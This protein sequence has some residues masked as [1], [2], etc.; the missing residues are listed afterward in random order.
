M[1]DN[2]A[3]DRIVRIGAISASFVDS[4][5]AMP[6]LLNSGLALDYLVF[7]CLAEGVMSI[8]ARARLAGQPAYVSD[9]VTGQM[10]PF[11]GEIARRGIKVV[12]NAGGLDPQG[13]ADA[14]SV[15][16][17]EAGV[18]L[19][20]ACI[21]GDDL[22]DRMDK[23]VPA[24]T[25]DMFDGSDLRARLGDADQPLSL[26]AYT[27]AFPIAAA[28]EAGADIVVT[29]RAVDSATALGPLIHE[30]GWTDD[31][32]DLLSAGTLVGHLIECTTQVCGATF[33]DWREVP[34]WANIGFP[35]AECRG[36][37]SAVITKPEG[38]GG[39]V[40]RATVSE[41]MLYEIGDPASY[42]VPDVICD[43]TGVKAEEIGENR[44][45]ICGARGRGRPEKLKA[46]LTWDAGW[47]G[48]ALAPIMGFEAAAKAE[49]TAREL[50]IRCERLARDMGIAP[51]TRFHADVIGETGGGASMAICRMIADH[52]SAQGAGLFARE[53]SSIMT[54]MAVGTSVP[55]GTSVKPLTYFASL[56]LDRG[57]VDL[58]VRVDGERIEFV[59]AREGTAEIPANPSQPPCPMATAD[60]A[61]ALVDLAWVRSGD[62]GDLF[63]VGV[64]ARKSEYLPYLFDALTPAA[65]A[66]HYAKVLRQDIPASAVTRFH[67][68]GIAAINLLITGSMDGGMLASPAFD[69]AAKAR[70]QLLL[71]FPVP[72]PA[73]LITED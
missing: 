44:V 9:F 51:F 12:A 6:Q 19:R 39:L 30:F 21:C 4:R 18:E 20:I 14:L 62:K 66:A 45:A 24:G 64:I 56:L 41:Q 53:Q 57:D 68:P 61:V 3:T 40:S 36:D 11:L 16:A 69:P 48:S 15:A 55:L 46:A 13:C 34:D 7:D 52:P 1:P 54:S 38:T 72:V 47:R 67:V 49:R 8:L 29:G 63:N 58:S 26:A 17:K 25:P 22:S 71:D 50:F 2:P 43:W 33:T 31:D 37:G 35:V 10:T 42:I 73:N 23:L 28:L 5:I 59:A 65:V 60:T 27:G 70:G 32:F